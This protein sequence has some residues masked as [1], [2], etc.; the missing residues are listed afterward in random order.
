M[1]IFVSAP[2]GKRVREAFFTEKARTFLEENFEVEYL[3]LDRQLL[4]EEIREYAADADVLMTGWGH[5]MLSAELLKGTS[6]KVIAH[7][8][9][10]VADYV[11]PDVYEAGIHVISGNALYAQSV[12]EGT[13]AYMLLALRR[14]SDYVNCVRNGGW[15][16]EEGTEGLL[17]QTVGIIG[18]GTISRYLISMLK[19]FNVQIKIYSGHEIDP[20]YLQEHSAKQV[21]LEEIFSTCKI[22]SVHSAQ[23][24]RTRGMIGKEHFG[25]LQDG[26]LFVN[27]ARGGIIREEEMI[28]ALE[29]NRFKAVLDVYCEEHL[30]ADSKLRQLPNAYCI[31]HKGG[32]TVDRCPYVVLALAADLLRFMQGQPMCHEIS[33]TAAKR[34]TRERTAG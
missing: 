9:G 10:S 8:G 34:M 32:P 26:A 21:S 22:V 3:S 12:A 30:A 24:D 2:A 7:T 13:I 23:N 14:M 28:A 15:K 4:P 29:E 27:T 33:L 5:C 11:M 19:P 17:D 1:K 18:F 16:I 25:L 20:A 31:P 6:I